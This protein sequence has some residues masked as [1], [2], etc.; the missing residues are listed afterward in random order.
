MEFKVT[1]VGHADSEMNANKH[2]AI[3]SITTMSELE[4]GFS[5]CSYVPM[6]CL[7]DYRSVKPY[8]G[9]FLRSLA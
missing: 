2:V 3:H 9:I 6:I 5:T 8:P 1:L 7:P 4:D